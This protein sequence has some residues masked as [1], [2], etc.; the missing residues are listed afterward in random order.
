[1]D[2]VTSYN[3]QGFLGCARCPRQSFVA[4]GRHQAKEQPWMRGSSRWCAGCG[5]EELGVGDQREGVW[6]MTHKCRGSI[7][8]FSISKSVEPKE[9]QKEMISGLQQGI[10]CKH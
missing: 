7:K 5:H 4:G 1:M 6:V 2:K 10:F 3:L 8:A 9:E